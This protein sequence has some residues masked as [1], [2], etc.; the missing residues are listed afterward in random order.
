M[1]P[2]GFY[3]DTNIWRDYFEDRKDN[4]KPLGEFAFRFLQECLERKIPLLVST[5][6]VSEL[7]HY[8]SA[9]RIE[10]V[11][12]P[13][14][15]IIVKVEI[16]REEHESAKKLSHVVRGSHYADILHAIIARNHSAI[17]VTRDKGFIHLADLVEVV[18]PEEITFD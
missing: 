3:P 13:Y 4:M 9:P 16:T 6:V 7:R 12:E 18:N 15:A 5:L 8:Y 10:Q 17:L 11:F 14:A 2:L 1:A